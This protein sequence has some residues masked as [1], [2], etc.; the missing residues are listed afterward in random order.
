MSQQVRIH[1]DQKTHHSPTPTTGADLYELLEIPDTHVLYREVTGDAEDQLIRIDAA[2]V[3]LVEDAHFHSAQAPE[4]FY[5]IRVNTDPF[6]VEH[7]KVTFAEVVHLAFPT[8]PGGLDPKFTV[9]YEHAQSKPHHGELMEGQSV[10][11]KKHGTLFDAAHTNR[12]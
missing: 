7:E 3:D 11:V 9:T 5:L 10:E 1:V 6:I 8:P 4:H 12:S 2:H